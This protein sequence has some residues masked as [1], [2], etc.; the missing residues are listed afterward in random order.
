MR[1]TGRDQ[2]SGPQEGLKM[3]SFIS[4]IRPVD[5][6]PIR[7]YGAVA[8]VDP[9]GVKPSLDLLQQTCRKSR[10]F[11]PRSSLRIRSFMPRPGGSTLGKMGFMNSPL[12]CVRRHLDPAL[13]RVIPFL[14]RAANL[15]ART[16]RHV[17]LPARAHP[18][19]SSYI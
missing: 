8:I 2:S 16:H 19:S 6:F 13:D 5:L 9:L 15:P 18:S 4:G 17:P 12:L 1:L 10:I 14:D 11:R 7:S 3:L